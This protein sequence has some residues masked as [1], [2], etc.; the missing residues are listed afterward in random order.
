V[1]QKRCLRLPTS[2]IPNSKGTTNLEPST[3]PMPAHTGRFSAQGT[4]NGKTQGCWDLKNRQAA[5]DGLYYSRYREDYLGS[6]GSKM[7]SSRFSFNTA[8][9]PLEDTRDKPGS[10]VIS[11]TFGDLCEVVAAD[12]SLP[13]RSFE[14]PL[15][16]LRYGGKNCD[17]R[18]GAPENGTSMPTYHFNFSN[19]LRRTV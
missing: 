7:A 18:N 14:F 15:C 6:A 17:Q 5:C 16:E 9:G 13:Q 4:N 2:D 12:A 1:Q 3:L 8:H 19:I 11:E 10:V